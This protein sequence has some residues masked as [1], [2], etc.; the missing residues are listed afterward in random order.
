MTRLAPLA[1]LSALAVLGALLPA[2]LAA[3]QPG[4]APAV[5]LAAPPP[6][7]G[8]ATDPNIDRGFLLPTAETQPRG[9]IT[10]N[11]YELFI[12]G[13]T[14]GVTDD[15]QLSAT[16]ILPMFEDMP[17]VATGSGKVRLVNAGR[18]RVAAHG[19]VTVVTADG[20]AAYLSTV[21][22]TG[23]VCLDDGCHSMLSATLGAMGAAGDD[24]DGEAAVYYGASLVQK[25]APRAKL[26][27]ELA[28][29]SADLTSDASERIEALNYGI[30]FYGPNLAADVGFVRPLGLED[31]ELVMGVPFVNL[32]YR[33]L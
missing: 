17:L 11:D 30:R 7:T 28:G 33:A 14:V 32:S 8:A 16:T 10:F 24:A 21:G 1:P 26:L 3:A 27:L 4:E 31:D 18:L 6:P 15:L 23:S 12:T 9:S 25:I 2:S 22:G 20:E 29:A 13:L 19:S 5:E